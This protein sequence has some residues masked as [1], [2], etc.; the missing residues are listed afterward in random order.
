MHTSDRIESRKSPAPCGI[1]THGLKSFALQALS[2]SRCH[3]IQALSTASATVLSLSRLTLLFS[4]EFDVNQSIIVS[5]IR[6]PSSSWA[7]A[8]NISYQ[9]LA[10]VFPGLFNKNGLLLYRK[11]WHNST[12]RSS[13]P[14]SS[15]L[16]AENVESNIKGPRPEPPSSEGHFN[17]LIKLFPYLREIFEFGLS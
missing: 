5:K 13:R 1:W 15:H 4:D 3:W 11:L 7:T 6:R 9:N 8:L 16:I 10:I 2:Y 12:T 14:N 17:L